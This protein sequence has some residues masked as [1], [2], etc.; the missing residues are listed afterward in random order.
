[1]GSE[2]L[3]VLGFFRGEAVGKSLSQIYPFRAKR[4]TGKRVRENAGFYLR[5]KNENKEYHNISSQA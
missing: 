2:K 4:E 3:K 1:M 5:R